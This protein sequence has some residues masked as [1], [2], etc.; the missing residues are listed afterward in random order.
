MTDATDDVDAAPDVPT[1]DEL[2]EVPSDAE[3]ETPETRIAKLERAVRLLGIAAGVLGILAIVL[4]VLLA[5]LSGQLKVERDDRRAVEQTAGRLAS[6]LVTYDYQHLDQAKAGVLRDS[7]GKF[8]REYEQAFGG[9]QQLI[10]TAKAKSSATVK[11]VFTS[12]IESNASSAIVVL[13]QVTEGLAG[14]QQRVD[15]WV[16]LDMVKTGG[17]W[18]ADGVT[19]LNFGQAPA[20]GDT[21]ASPTPTSAPSTPPTTGG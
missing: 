11:D 7:T 9:L 15:A 6:A 3:P 20:S 5:R 19:N 8:R 2:V 16:E 12:S 13:D 21:G 4:A 18:K 1:R 10:T 17:R 14:K